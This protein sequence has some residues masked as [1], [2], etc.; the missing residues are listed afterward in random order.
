MLPGLVYKIRH[1][2]TTG[3][4]KKR[5]ARVGVEEGDGVVGI[6]NFGIEWCGLPVT[7]KFGEA[8]VEV[9]NVIGLIDINVP[10]KVLL[11]WCLGCTC[12]ICVVC[13]QV[14]VCISGV[15]R[16]WK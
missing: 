5:L 2:P 13:V 3:C 12:G 1:G 8:A 4:N 6:S 14:G 11:Y 10:S 7:G 9:A 15:V 16:V